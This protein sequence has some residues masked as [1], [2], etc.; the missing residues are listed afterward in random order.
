M[1]LRERLKASLGTLDREVAWIFLVS[2]VVQSV[3]WYFGRV[4]FFEEHFPP[5]EGSTI[6]GR[7][8][9]VLLHWATAFVL[10]AVV[11]I[12]VI[13]IVLGQRLA[14]FGLRRGEGSLW[15]K[16]AIVTFVVFAA[17]IVIGGA[18]MADVGAEYPLSKAAASSWKVMAL[19]ALAYGV[20]YVGWEVHF[21]GFILFGLARKLGPW[22][23]IFA[24]MVPSVLIHAGKPP[25]ETFGAILAGIIWGWLALETRSIVG[26]LLAHW[27]LG[28]TNDVV[29][30]IHFHGL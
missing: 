27:A 17:P 15:W 2:V 26:P 1:K 24:Q 8:E 28:V 5:P 18:G 19:Y 12:V 14:D 7:I 4:S 9:P 29:M 22:P 10:F 21:R 11:S 23:A 25:G 20:Y 30:S 16:G 6:F 13:R 3:Y